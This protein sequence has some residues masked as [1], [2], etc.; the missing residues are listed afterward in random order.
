MSDSKRKQSRQKNARK[1]RR[2]TQPVRAR[3]QNQPSTRRPRPRKSGAGF[4]ATRI[5][6][7]IGSYFG[8]RG[9]R[10][11]AS[12]GDLFRSITGF[13]DYKVNSNTLATN[14]DALPTF[15]NIARGTRVTHRE[16]LF[17]VITSP[18]AGAF[19]IQ[20]IPI[21][22]ALRA[23]FPWLSAS[24]EQYQQYQ[25]NGLVYEFKSNSY[26][27]LSST[28]TASGTVVMSTNYNVLE[29]PFP[30]KFTMEQSQYTCSGKPSKDLLHPIECAK[31]ETPTSTLY[32]RP[33]AVTIGDL[34]LYDWGNF[35]IATVGTQGTSTNIGELWVTYDITLLKPKLGDTVDVYDHYVLPPVN[36]LPG[37][38]AYFGSVGQ[39]PV[40]QADS[41]L[42]SSLAAN[43]SGD[44][45]GGYDTIVFPA[46]FTG[47]VMIYYNV[48]LTSTVSATLSA[49]ILVNF[50]GGA[51]PILASSSTTSNNQ[52]FNNHFLYNGNGGTTYT[53]FVQVING[54]SI[55]FTAGTNSG[56]PFGADLFILAL[57]SSFY[58]L[59]LVLPPVSLRR[60]LKRLEKEVVPRPKS[61]L[62]DEDGDYHMATDEWP[63]QKA[64]D[65][66]PIP[67][68]LTRGALRSLSPTDSKRGSRN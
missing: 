17:D 10:I 35:Y 23:S 56:V 1:A 68:R 44:F 8:A 6:R 2:K 14:V 11:G 62:V 25:L 66:I 52:G 20:Q 64:S 34:R 51:S 28:N 26:D 63:S 57:P 60:E 58:T 54:G 49:P 7:T 33:G 27:A 61:D 50:G 3:R 42:G 67:S 22:P 12:A 15:G 21:Q 39:P 18:T 38:P 59:P 29:P 36:T 55:Q 16:F 13:G 41:D 37:G 19:N 53:D 5:G 24:A 31:V 47:K 9:G 48:T 43:A 32:T 30:N 46:G 65:P 4:N 40:L 45:S